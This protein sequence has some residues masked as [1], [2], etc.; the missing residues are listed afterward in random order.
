MG[1]PWDDR[2][3]KDEFHY[4]TEP[5][6]FVCAHALRLEPGGEVLCLGSGEGRNAV[7]LA[8][9]GL[10]VTGVDGSRVGLQK[11]RRL[12]ERSG[13]SVTWEQADLAGYDLGQA[14]WDGIVSI[15]CHVQ[16][17]IRADLHRRIVRA[18]KPGGVLLLEGYRPEQIGRGTGGP[19]RVEMMV[20]AGMLRRE[21]V[22]LEFERLEDLEREIHE[23]GGHVGMGAVVQAIA[24]RP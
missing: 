7:F 3:D 12:A 19:P 24:R 20:D 15:F 8:G 2:Y 11:G 6:D 13:V 17:E 5:N 23:G 10:R 18:L 1:N 4:G 22:G 16:P 21:L 9:R 14:R